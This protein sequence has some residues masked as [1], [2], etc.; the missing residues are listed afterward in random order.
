MKLWRIAPAGSGFWDRR[1]KWLES[2][3]AADVG[4]LAYQNRWPIM[5]GRQF[6]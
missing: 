6:N 4:L 3:I 5:R 1:G 2:A